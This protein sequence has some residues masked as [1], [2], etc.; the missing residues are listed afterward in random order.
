MFGVVLLL[1]TDQPQPVLEGELMGSTVPAL[2]VWGEQ[3]RAVDP[4]GAAI[5]H[6]AMPRSEVVVMPGVGHLPM[7]EAPYR[8]AQDYLAFRARLAGG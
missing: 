1:G 7:L 3:D 6:Q 8:S 4:S 5:L 2:I